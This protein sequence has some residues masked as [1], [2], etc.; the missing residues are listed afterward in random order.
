MYHSSSLLPAR[1]L[2]MAAALA[3]SDMARC[4]A[5]LCRRSGLSE[6]RTLPVGLADACSAS[7]FCANLS[8]S[9]ADLSIRACSMRSLNSCCLSNSCLSSMSSICL[10]CASLR[11]ASSSCRRTYVGVMNLP[12]SLMSH[13]RACSCSR[14]QRLDGKSGTRTRCSETTRS[15][16]A[17]SSPMATRRVNR[18]YT[19]FCMPSKYSTS[20]MRVGSVP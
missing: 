8:L 6:P 4:S 20:C 12:R 13:P 18:L 19:S 2:A 10:C 5:N 16:A 17:V 11:N 1:L 15:R 14:T 9:R 7:V 3:A